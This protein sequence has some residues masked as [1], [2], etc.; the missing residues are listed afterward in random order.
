MTK[1]ELVA[2]I[3]GEVGLEQTVVDRVLTGLDAAMI[4]IVKSGDELR[5]SG[6]FVLDVVDRP[7]RQ[8]RNPQTGESMTI[9]AG[10]QPRI[11]VGAR[12]KQAAKA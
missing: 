5:L 3:A 6:L 12:L 1:T 8:G 2:K 7:E 10:R 11:R 9:A 4:D